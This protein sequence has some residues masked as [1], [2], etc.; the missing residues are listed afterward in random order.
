M[1]RPT[2]QALAVPAKPA[3]GLVAT[4]FDPSRNELEHYSAEPVVAVESREQGCETGK[5]WHWRGKPNGFWVSVKG[6]DDWPDWCNAESFGLDRLGIC[7]RVEIAP[8]ANVLHVSGVEAFNAFDAR[9]GRDEKL[10][11]DATYS[12]RLID[13]AA[14]ARDYDGIIIA[15]YVWEHR[16]EDWYYGWDCASGVI[17]N[18][19][20]VAAIA[21]EAQRAETGTGSVHE[22]A[23]PKGHRPKPVKT[24]TPQ[25]QEGE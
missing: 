9:Y 24:V 7:H 2:D 4:R 22:G 1:A 12:K 17:W 5:N 16:F 23:G 11:P 21:T 14:V 10:Y 8:S 20:A 13:W 25:A 6:E 18:A 15:P 19:E 3:S